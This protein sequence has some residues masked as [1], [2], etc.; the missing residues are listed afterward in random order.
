MNIWNNV[1]YSMSKKQ[2]K[3]DVQ[4]NAKKRNYLIYAWH[5]HCVTFFPLKFKANQETRM[6]KFFVFSFEILRVKFKLINDIFST[7]DITQR[8]KVLNLYCGITLH[9]YV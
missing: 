1:K 7:R 4:G 2:K 8:L 6:S 9:I 3:Y 5:F